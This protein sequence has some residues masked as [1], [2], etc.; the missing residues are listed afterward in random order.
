[1]FN[2]LCLSYPVSSIRSRQSSGTETHCSHRTHTHVLVIPAQVR[3]AE[4]SMCCFCCVCT[5]CKSLCVNSSEQPCPQC[6]AGTELNSRSLSV[7]APA[8]HTF[9]HALSLLMSV[10]GRRTVVGK[11]N[12]SSLFGV[13][14]GSRVRTLGCFHSL[15]P[16]TK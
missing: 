3:E 4:L 2:A 5:G 11:G 1:M 16:Q 10:L 14:V 13:F 8:L 7:R 15:T 6:L 9:V 12:L